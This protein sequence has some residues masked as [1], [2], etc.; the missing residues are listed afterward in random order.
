MTREQIERRLRERLA[1][2]RTYGGYGTLSDVERAY[3]VADLLPWIL[4]L[5][6][7]ARSDA[8]LEAEDGLP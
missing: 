4:E 5:C 7:E 2:M 8:L 6:E 1:A 3:I